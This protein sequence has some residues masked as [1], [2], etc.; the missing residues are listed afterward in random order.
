MATLREIN[1]S[2]DL[3]EVYE[4]HL[5]LDVQNEIEFCESE[6]LKAQIK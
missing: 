1:E 5:V 2:W 4:A 3:S 6:R